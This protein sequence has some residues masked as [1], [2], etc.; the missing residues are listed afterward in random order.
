MSKFQHSVPLSRSVIQK[1]LSRRKEMLVSAKKGIL[2]RAAIVVMELVGFYILQSYTLLLDALSSFLD[3]SFSLLLVLMLRFADRPP[4]REHPFGHGRIEPLAGM[5]MGFLILIIGIMTAARQLISI[6]QGAEH[7]EF[8]SAHGWIIPLVAILMLEISHRLLKRTAKAQKSDALM[9][10]AWHYRIDALSNFLALIALGLVAIFPKWAYPIDQMG[11]LAIALFMI[12]IGGYAGWTN[13]H[14]LVDRAPDK[15]YFD[16]VRTAALSVEGVHAT[17]KTLIQTYGPDAHVSID[18]E[19]EPGLSV[20][21]AHAITQ[22]V[23]REIQK[24]WPQV[25]E[26]I[27]HVEPFYPNDHQE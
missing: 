15:S 17:E 19:V 11:A 22:K 9:V 20:Q 23:R 10:D 5:L 3:V 24:K 21:E 8:A 7:P 12:G 1:R 18:I 16:M 2:L 14:P 6:F 13:L 27:V 25:R 4:D 26:V